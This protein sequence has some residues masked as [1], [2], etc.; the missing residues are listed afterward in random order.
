MPPDYPVGIGLVADPS[1]RCI[2]GART[3]I[4]GWPTRVMRLSRP[5]ASCVEAWLNG[6]KV[7]TADR[8]RVLAKRLLEASMFHPVIDTMPQPGLDATVVVPVFDDPQGLEALLSTLGASFETVV[9]DDASREPEAIEELAERYGARF[10]GCPHNRGPAAARNVGLAAVRTPLAVFVDS[11]AVIE[12]AAL[13][14]LLA[15]FCDPQVQGVAP[16]IKSLP[17]DSLLARYEQVFSCLD[18]GEHRSPVGPRCRM[19]YVP[20]TVL[21][22]RTETVRSVGG[23]DESLRWGEDVDFIWRLCAEG[24]TIR[25]EPEVQAWHRPRTSWGAWLQQRRHYGTSAAALGERHGSVVAPGRTTSATSAA[26][27]AAALGRPLSGLSIAATTTS[28]AAYRLWRSHPQSQDRAR[29]ALL[30]TQ[31]SLRRHLK[32]ALS[33][34]RAMR[35]AW[36][37]LALVI[38]IRSRRLRPVVLAGIVAPCVQDAWT[39]RG[40]SNQ[41]DAPTSDKSPAAFVALRFVD[42]AAYCLGVWQGVIG[43]RSLT[44][45]KPV[46]R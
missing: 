14:K 22:V 3:L 34:A 23:F 30:A 43:H 7:G 10:V 9:V 39:T 29:L 2:G 46:L 33:L 40:R 28:A 32:A 11:D 18:M 24:H 5:G 13:V 35:R 12:P 1:L 31:M 6:G 45:I 27:V 4:G 36:L 37:P 20:A 19:R 38:A 21:A 44:A 42:D 16:R 26:W 25:Y 17:G 41:A 8:E 15:H